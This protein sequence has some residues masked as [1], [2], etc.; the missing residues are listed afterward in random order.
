MN[1]KLRCSLILLFLF[2]SSLYPNTEKDSLV[3]SKNN[4]IN[5][6]SVS[7]SK[8]LMLHDLEKKFPLPKLVDQKIT[9]P[10]FTHDHIA[11][12]YSED[13]K[14]LPKR[15]EVA[16]VFGQIQTEGR[17]VDTFRNEDIQ[18]LPIGIKYNPEEDN[19]GVNV[20]LGLV[21]ATVNTQYIEFTAFAR[22][23]LPQTDEKGNRI[24]LFFAADNLKMNHAGGIIGDANLVLL[25]DVHIPWNG[26]KWLLTLKGGFNYNTGDVQELTYFNMDC[27]GL[28]ELGVQAEVQ[29]SRDMILPVGPNGESLPETRSYKTGDGKTIS[30]PNR[31]SGQFGMVVKSWNDLIAEVSLPPFVLASMPDSFM[32]SVNRAIFD[33]SDERTLHN[34]FPDFYHENDLLFPSIESWRGFYVESLQIGMPKPFKTK[35]SISKNKRVSF[36]AYHMIID[37]YGVSGYF[38]VNNVIPLSE[39]RTNKSKAWSMS[40]DQL[41]IELAANRFVGAS[42]DG[43]ILLPI[44]EKL[45]ENSQKQETKLDSASSKRGL[46][47]NGFI[48]EEE[49]AVRLSSLDEIKFNIW[50]ARGRLAPN[51]AI[52]LAVVEDNFRPKAILHGDMT[53][54]ADVEQ[55]SDISTSV[56]EDEGGD[57][58]ENVEQPKAI[59]FK[60]IEFQD[61][62]LQT[63]SPLFQVG[64]FGY[65]GEVKLMNFPVSIADIALTATDDFT[66]LAF[67]LKLNL[68]SKKDKGFAARTRL[69]LVGQIKE[70]NYKQR[71]KFKKVNVQEIYLKA[72]LGGFSLEGD[73]QL[74]QNNP[75]YGNGFTADLALQ[76]TALA[77]ISIES[78]AIFGKKDFRYWYVDALVGNLPM[79]KLTLMGLDAF[80]GGAFY[81]MKRKNFG[82]AFSPSGLGYIPDAESG[83]GLKANV[84]FS[85]VEDNIV[86]GGAGFEILFNRTG[87]INRMG[88][89]GE[90]HVMDIVEI[91]NPARLVADKMEEMAKKAG[92]GGVVDKINKSKLLKSFV[93]RAIEEYPAKV[94]GEGGIN[95]Y[96][97]IEFDFQNKALHGEYDIYVNVA[98]GLI[99]G[100]SSGG[101]SGWGV[102]HLSPEEWYLHM[103]TPENRLGLAFSIGPFRKESGGYFMIGDYLLP[104]PPPPPEVAQILGVEAETLNYMRD[105]NALRS[106]KGFAFGQDFKVDTGDIHF[107]AFYAR[108][109]AGAGYDIMLRDYGEAKCANTGDQVGING[110]Y[111]NGQAYAYLQGELGIRIKLFFLKKKIPIIKGGAAVLLQAKAPNP[112]WLRGYVGGY[113]D[114]LGGMVKGRFRFKV[115]LGEECE[116][117]DA[118]PLGG[119]KMITDLTPKE[120]SSEIDVFA[121]PQATFSMKVGEPIVIPEDEADKTYKIILEKFRIVDSKGKEIPGELEWSYMNDRATF[122]SDDILPPNE[123]LKVEVEVSFQ[124]K[125]NGIFK[126][127]VVDGKK[128]VETEV[129]NF[130]TGEAPNHIPLHNIEYSYPVVDQKQFYR[131]EYSKGYIQLRRGQDY[132][133]DNTQW[134]SEIH[135]ADEFGKK[136]STGFNYNNADNEVYY[137]LPKLDKDRKYN[138]TIISLPKAGGQVDKGST[139]TKT[140]SFDN[141]NT[142]EITTK[143]ADNVSQNGVIER[144]SYEFKTSSYKTFISKVNDISVTDHFW[145]T[146]VTSDVVYLTT[147]VKSHEGFEI[148]EVLGSEYTDNKALVSI[149]ADLKDTYFTADIDPILYKVYPE[150]GPYKLNRDITEYGFRPK[151]ALPVLSYYRN[152]L[153]TNSHPNLLATSF[154]YRYN[155]PLQYYYDFRD[156]E[157]QVLNDYVDGKLKRPDRFI[158][159]LDSRYWYMRHGKYYVNLYYTLPGN[160]QTTKASYMFKHT[161]KVR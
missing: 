3:F 72:N 6:S 128:A 157:N 63:E 131:E 35:N 150:N 12:E 117:I 22:I 120:G 152:G 143:T 151:K 48:S 59:E 112:I 136:R 52:E 13:K 49:F 66:N 155:L 81:K 108:F 110:W 19:G 27:D 45:Q 118:S 78:K 122:F 107:L 119:I 115:T 100:R 32:F 33:F 74:M 123:Q 153:Q 1:I 146:T 56:A 77:G 73:L 148:N 51:S 60:G 15:Q 109:M 135:F 47:Y 142:V 106:G 4:T 21:S 14:I 90:A 89:Y 40:V 68:M 64:Y 121:A 69:E 114:L 99:K 34:N 43:R 5:T 105:E 55:E 86:N 10:E 101:R 58:W 158:T 23:T 18:T 83:L 147:D 20:E 126:T 130:V 93:D 65:Q 85:I 17:W 104:S 57:E 61:L 79:S 124:E 97:G 36:E 145:S 54:R 9:K 8:F 129:R 98:G 62:V 42:F 149:E 53:I 25:G 29:F 96:M 16:A 46:R 70:E 140:T 94:F 160:K 2:V 67:D 28:K 31:V 125:I 116:F 37:D 144:L 102:I 26:G 82:S 138:Y 80:G 87:G 76:L 133:F 84:L 134:K 127:I 156:I 139:N 95:A 159:I 132:L 154:P 161:N 141:D 92:L 111:A 41:G 24:E 75:E 113:Y 88:F 71:W 137:N 38:S 103:G 91:V 44:S 7:T 11:I 50:K 30:I 39:G